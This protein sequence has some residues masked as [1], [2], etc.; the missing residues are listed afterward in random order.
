M[1]ENK[2][3]E[4]DYKIK[5]KNWS[6]SE[7]NESESN[8]SKSNESESKEEEN[9]IEVKEE[10]K[11]E[12]KE[13]K[14][15]NEIILINKMLRLPKKKM[16][17]QEYNQIISK[18]LENIPDSAEFY[19]KIEKDKKGKINPR[20]PGIFIIFE[21]IDFYFQQFQK[22]HFFSN[23]KTSIPKSINELKDPEQI[24]ESIEDYIKENTSIEALLNSA[25]INFD[26]IVSDYILFFI[27]NRDKLTKDS[28]DIKYIYKI[29]SNLIKIKKNNQKLE[30]YKYFID[31]IILLNCFSSHITYPLNAIK[32]LND[33]NIIEDIY[34][35]ILKEITK[36]E[37][38]KESNIIF[39]IIESFFNLLLTEI[40]SN[41]KLIP[42]LNYIHLFLMNIINTLNLPTKSFYTYMQFKTFYR[43]IIEND[44]NNK[45]LNDIYSEIYK[46]KDAF[47]DPNKKDETLNNYKTF[48]EKLISDYKINNYSALRTFIVDIFAY[49][50]KKYGE[51]EEL[52]SIILDV[53]SKDNGS[54]F[55]CSNKI[56]NIF[57]KKYIFEKPPKDEEN[58]RNILENAYRIKKVIIE[59]NDKQENIKIKIEEKV[60]NEEIK[61]NDIG[62]IKEDKKKSEENIAKDKDK[63]KKNKEDN[64]SEIK[65]E[66]E[67][68]YINEIKEQKYKE[69]LFLKKYYEIINTK[70]NEKIKVMIDEIIQQVFGFYFNGYFMSYLDSLNETNTYEDI[71]DFE[72]FDDNKLFFKACIDFLEKIEKPFNGKEISIF[73]ANAFIQSFLYVFIKYFYKNIKEKK[74]IGKY[75]LDNIFKILKG[76]SNFRRVVQIYIFRLIYYNINDNTFTGF[77]EFEVNDKSYKSFREQFL[78][79]YSFEEPPFELKFYCKKIFEDFLNDDAESLPINYKLSGYEF[80]NMFPYDYNVVNVKMINNNETNFSSINCYENNSQFITKLA[81]LIITNATRHLIN[82]DNQFTEINKEINNIFKKNHKSINS[83][84]NEAMFELIGNLH[85]E[86][87]DNL[88]NILANTSENDQNSDKDKEEM[89]KEKEKY[90]PKINPSIFSKNN[91]KNKYNQRVLGIFL[92]SLKISLTTFI[93]DEKE[94]YFYSYLTMSESS[95][96]DIIDILDSSYIP[97]YNLDIKGLKD[98][99]KDKDNYS[100][101]WDTSISSLTLR[102]ILYSI[103]FFNLLMKKLNDK[104]INNYSINGNYS[105]LR[106]IVCIWNILEERLIKDGIPIIEIYFNLIIKYLPYILKKCTM[107]TIK[108][109]SKAQNFVNEFGKFIDTIRSN[110]KEYSLNFIDTKMRNIIQELNNP[111]KYDFDEYP[112]LAYYTV[113]AKPNRDEIINAIDN[114]DNYLILNNLFD[115]ENPRGNF[116]DG[117]HKNIL[118]LLNLGKYFT[119]SINDG[120]KIVIKQIEK[121]GNLIELFK[122]QFDDFGDIFNGPNEWFGEFI[123]FEEEIR[124]SIKSTNEVIEG[125]INDK[126]KYNPSYKY[127][128]QEIYEEKEFLTSFDFEIINLNLAEISKYQYY[129]NFLNNYIYRKI[130]KSN[131]TVDYFDYKT[132]RINSTELDENLF[133]IL[134][135]NKKIFLDVDYSK[136]FFIPKYDLF[137]KTTNNQFFLSNYLFEYPAREELTVDQIDNINKTIQNIVNSMKIFDSKKKL[138]NELINKIEK[139]QNDIEVKKKAID[140][141]ENNN[142]ENENIAKED[143]DF[144]K[145]DKL[146][147]IKKLEK[148]IDYNENVID[149]LNFKFKKVNSSLKAN[150]L[151]DI[152]FSLQTLLHYIYTLNI[153]ESLPLLYICHNLQLFK[154]QK[155]KL[156]SLLDQNKDL[157]LSYLFS[158][159]EYFESLILPEF[160][161]HINEGYMAPIPLYLAQKIIYIFEKDELKSN[162]IFTK[163]EFIEAIRKCLSRYIVSSK[164]EK[165]H[166]TE[167]LNMDLFEL[168]LKKDLWGKNIQ[169]IKLKES[170]N[171]INYYIKYPIKVK[172]IFNLFEIL[173]GVESKNYF[174]FDDFKEEEKKEKEEDEYT[175]KFREEKEEKEK[176]ED[177]GIK[178]DEK[179][180]KIELNKEPEENEKD[181]SYLNEKFQLL[182]LN[183]AKNLKKRLKKSL[184]RIQRRKIYIY[185]L[186]KKS[187]LI[188]KYMD[189]MNKKFN[190]KKNKDSSFEVLL[191]EVMNYGNELNLDKLI[192]KF[193]HFL[194][195]QDININISKLNE[196]K[197]IINLGEDITDVVLFNKNKIIVSYE[198]QHIK[199]Y[200]FDR[201]TFREEPTFIPL[202][203]MNVKDIKN[204]NIVNCMKELINGT[205]LLGT[206]NGYIMNLEL[207]EIKKKNRFEY[208]L[209]LLNQMQLENS[210]NINKLIEINTN[211]FISSF[212][213]QEGNHNIVWHNNENKKKLNDGEIYKANNYLIVI[214][215]IVIFYDIKKNFEEIGK[216]EIQILNHE[217]LNDNYL[218]GEDSNDWI[219]HIINI[220]EMK[221]IKQLFYEP[222]ESFIVKN[223]CNKSVFDLPNDFRRKLM[224]N[225]FRRKLIRFEL[226]NGND[227]IA[228]N[229]ESIIVVSSSHL[230][231]LFDEFFIV[232]ENGN[233]SCYGCFEL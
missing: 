80:D 90:I 201:K 161:Y 11:M 39:I 220:K 56:F 55:T 17:N 34:A 148:E 105:C 108:D 169:M 73:L 36:Y 208:N 198:N 94:K 160:I 135:Y 221:I 162:I 183:E 69:D 23:Y 99:R 171:Y 205:L 27:C 181:N 144:V 182:E 140:E 206:K 170:F 165:E 185:D 152:C 50:L 163:I 190:N 101:R 88:K 218:I 133:S 18:L 48:Y 167:E 53:L 128:F 229:K 118:I 136:K 191:T 47:I 79:K 188:V 187:K 84:F 141:N 213:N 68:D 192:N 35:K 67:I 230:T 57:L 154:F 164:I 31:I 166:I 93:F 139:L 110:Y 129:P 22:F 65:N 13:E 223:I 91:D 146:L 143:I 153:N 130:F 97:G 92:Y 58:C 189:I 49:E 228:N 226:I 77:K 132:F 63:E 179:E 62:N 52:F 4:E 222:S 173:I 123:K 194:E 114:D 209:K 59:E 120:L 102:F 121:Y 109:K 40:L 86:L 157:K 112:L 177:K 41:N 212:D 20:I 75:D 30:R 33:E 85:L 151:I 195:N 202:E 21:N 71:G 103:I 9:K 25:K 147:E 200:L 178:E 125:L 215:N 26:D 96:K 156:I 78:E 158:L 29:L 232:C 225:D 32:F 216:I 5:R 138:E 14:N 106:M 127:L 217:I 196:K 113:Q 95:S 207:I 10:N 126:I 175:L 1:I 231:N 45:S 54:A 116:A 82:D 186:M 159:Y 224:P 61:E 233:V 44:E 197:D 83:M 134:L 7:S 172:Y 199:I 150:Y 37:N 43:F 38:E 12:E 131:H 98:Q 117:R 66:N 176:E 145:Y 6:E 115:S 219:L 42:K 60:N 137:N 104:D 87:I 180:E 28:S 142:Q 100:D 211:M 107:E 122:S 74:Y 70:G 227:L 8:E 72:I 204:L 124:K 168:L 111:L 16:N 15:R 214:C 81:I 51:N 155:E 24:Y 3:E 184:K 89:E 174:K 210:E 64:H 76:K 19:S 119:E 193:N 203:I 2:S 46:L 149:I